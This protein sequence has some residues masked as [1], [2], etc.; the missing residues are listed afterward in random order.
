MV[1]SGIFT[2]NAEV[3]RKAGR[4]ASAVSG[5]E[6]YTNDYINQVE[7]YINCLARYNYSDNYATLNADVKLILK[8]AASNLAAIYVIQYDTTGYSSTREAENIINTN[9]ARFMQCIRLLHDQKTNTYI[10]GA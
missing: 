10:Q 1:E 5:A 2:N 9:W 4:G 6:A 8:E 3:L 7:S